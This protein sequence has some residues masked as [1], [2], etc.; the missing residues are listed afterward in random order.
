MS[1]VTS[2]TDTG[3]AVDYILFSEFDIDKGSVVRCQWPAPYPFRTETEI[4]EQALPD[5]SHNCKE[6]A[7][8]FFFRQCSEKVSTLDSTRSEEHTNEQNTENTSQ[9]TTE[10]TLND[11]AQLNLPELSTEKPSLQLNLSEEAPKLVETD[12]YYGL[13]FYMQKK[14]AN[15][16]RGTRVKAISVL[17]RFPHCLSLKVCSAFLVLTFLAIFVSSIGIHFLCL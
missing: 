14:I 5:G 2:D 13:N 16:R 7:T 6:D 17:S 3:F 11:T 15:A 1:I 9:F 8:V 12:F 10:S 4:A